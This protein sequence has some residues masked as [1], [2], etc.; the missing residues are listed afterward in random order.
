MYNKLALT[1]PTTSEIRTISTKEM[2][3]TDNYLKADSLGMFFNWV[4]IKYDR[5]H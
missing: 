5:S 1:F 3:D 4:R 2:T